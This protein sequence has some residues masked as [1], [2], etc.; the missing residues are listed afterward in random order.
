MVKLTDDEKLF[1][2]AD[3]LDERAA[4]PEGPGDMNFKVQHDAA[5]AAHL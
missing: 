2:H 4:A 1:L 5:K 3:I